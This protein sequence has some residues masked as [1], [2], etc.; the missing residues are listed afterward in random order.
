MRIRYTTAEDG[1]AVKQAVIYTED[2]HRIPL[3]DV[4][5]DALKIIRRL[6]GAG[7]GAYVVGGAVRDLLLGKKP[8]DFDVAT[9]ASPS[10]IRK[11]FRNS[12]VIG[13]RFRLVHVYF[14]EKIIE[15][16]TFR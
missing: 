7:H 5:Q 11:L 16:S 1:S 12:R 13:K 15:V 9:D 2:E 4:D 3:A 6:R 8:K 14:H 10:R